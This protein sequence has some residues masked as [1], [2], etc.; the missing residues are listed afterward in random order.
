MQAGSEEHRRRSVNA[1]ELSMTNEPRVASNAQSAV[2]VSVV[3]PCLN[4]AN[5]IGICV[6]KAF[7]AFET[8]IPMELASFR[9]G[10]T[11]D[12]STALCAL[13]ATRGSLVML[14]SSAFTLRRLCSS[15]PACIFYYGHYHGK[16]RERS[17][18]SP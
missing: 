9:Q 10:I 3:I 13:E 6:S 14:N 12:T 1:E 7:I 4:E 8:Q 16:V 2:E 18:E 5:S 11:T 15:L 17:S